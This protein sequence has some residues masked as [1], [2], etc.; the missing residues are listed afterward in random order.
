LKNLFKRWGNG[1][2][3]EFA[4]FRVHCCRG[5]AWRRSNER[6]KAQLD[7]KEPEENDLRNDTEKDL[8]THCVSSRVHIL[9][10]IMPNKMKSLLPTNG[11]ISSNL[12]KIGKKRPAEN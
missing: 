4:C 5:R 2:L 10:A 1:D 12:G 6:V 3:S 9:C 11:A 7:L 8:T